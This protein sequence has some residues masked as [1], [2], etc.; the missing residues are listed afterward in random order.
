MLVGGD[1]GG[2]KAKNEVLKHSNVKMLD[3]QKPI[4][5]N[6]VK[7]KVYNFRNQIKK[8]VFQRGVNDNTANKSN[9]R[10]IRN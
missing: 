10:K 2:E 9:K 8:K 1:T 7:S 4:N 5:F 3:K 6:K